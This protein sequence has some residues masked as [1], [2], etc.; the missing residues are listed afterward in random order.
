[1]NTIAEKI[2]CKRKELGMTQRAL[3]EALNVS[4]KTVSRWETGAQIPDAMMIPEIA[5][6]LGISIQ[7]LY[8]IE[9][10]KESELVV[11]DK[12]TTYYKIAFGIGFLIC[13]A[14][15][16]LQSVFVLSGIAKEVIRIGI[17]GIIAT[18]LVYLIHYKRVDYENI[19]WF[20]LVLIGFN[21]VLSVWLPPTYRIHWLGEKVVIEPLKNIILVVLFNLILQYIYVLF[22]K[23]KR[24]YDLNIPLAMNV[25]GLIFAIGY[26]VTVKCELVYAWTPNVAGTTTWRWLWLEQC[27]GIAFVLAQISNHIF[28]LHAWKEKGISKKWTRYGFVASIF[29]AVIS[30]TSIFGGYLKPTLYREMSKQL[31]S[32][33]IAFEVKRAEVTLETDEKQMNYSFSDKENLERFLAALREIEIKEAKWESLEEEANM[34]FGKNFFI[35]LVSE[36]DRIREI[37]FFNTKQ[38]KYD[39]KS[40]IV[41]NAV[42]WETLCR[43]TLSEY[44]EESL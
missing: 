16:I 28:L 1:M 11:E 12:K 33:S 24:E 32:E 7:E 3:A 15:G 37:Q 9:I 27:A 8:G 21:M 6:Q 14:G 18:D 35:T 13:V 17:L 44:E 22:W 25:I 20:G 30:V 19:K 2:L 10:K 31:V 40:Y 39:G 42:D 23:R 29:I 41:T 5:K 43:I 26:I 36:D 38:M 4:D 34:R